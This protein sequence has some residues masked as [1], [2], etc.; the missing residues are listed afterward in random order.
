VTKPIP[1]AGLSAICTAKRHHSRAFCRGLYVQPVTGKPRVQVGYA[2]R[3]RGMLSSWYVISP[4]FEAVSNHGTRIVLAH[5]HSNV[6][7]FQIRMV[8]KGRVLSGGR[9]ELSMLK[10]LF[11]AGVAPHLSSVSSMV[12]RQVSDVEQ[13]PGAATNGQQFASQTF[14][15]TNVSVSCH[16]AQTTLSISVPIRRK[17]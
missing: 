17:K 9:Y 15:V 8:R 2:R 10:T 6:A 1:R 3:S 4:C 12:Q 5:G 11:S 13:S 7:A 16:Q 14:S